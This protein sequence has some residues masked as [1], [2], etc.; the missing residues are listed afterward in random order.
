MIFRKITVEFG[1]KNKDSLSYPKSIGESE[2]PNRE[3]KKKVKKKRNRKK[4]DTI[5]AISMPT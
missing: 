2:F 4:I 3:K 1:M 5:F